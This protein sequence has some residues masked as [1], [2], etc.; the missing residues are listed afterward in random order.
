MHIG[1]DRQPPGA[2]PLPDLSE[3]PAVKFHDAIPKTARVYVVIEEEL[4]DPACMA[5]GAPQKECA[6][7]TT[8]VGTT[9]KSIDPGTPN[10]RRAYQPRR[11]AERCA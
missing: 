7:L 3:V 4:F 2:A 1:H 6:A 11:P 8:T 9:A 5:P 10:A